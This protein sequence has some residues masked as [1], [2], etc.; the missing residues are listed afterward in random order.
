MRL[1][2]TAIGRRVELIRHLKENF[3]VIGVDCSNLNAGK[4]FVDKFYKIPKVTEENYVDNLI[5]I[6]KREK[7]DVI[8]PLFE[9]EFNILDEARERFA[10]INT[11]LLLSSKE[12]LEICNNKMKTF[13]YFSNKNI[14]VPK[15]YE[16]I[17]IEKIIKSKS[18]ECFPLIIKPSCGMGS[19]GVFKINNIKELEFF[20]SYVKDGI[21]Q[22][23]ISGTEYTVDVLVDL[24]GKPVYI[25]PRERIEVKAGEVVKSATVKDSQI[26]EET[27][28]VLS[29]LREINKDGLTTAGPL[30]IQFIRDNNNKLYLLEINTRFGGGV[31]LSIKS[32]ANYSKKI[33]DMINNVPLSYCDDFE[34][35]TMMRYEEAVYIK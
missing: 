23:F 11:L 19:R 28:K 30:T 7:I 21:I 32:G 17:E 12:V 26:I 8:V 14:V 33:K 35:L 34:E 1:L 15:V 2:L 22:Q 3:E 20:K 29:A 5:D 10:K 31:T 18:I 16:I 27:K 9:N 4:D 6:C 13:C 25:I 24:S